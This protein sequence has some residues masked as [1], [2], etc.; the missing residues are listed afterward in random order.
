[1]A[2]TIAPPIDRPLNKTYLQGFTGWSTAFGPALAE[3]SS[4]RQMENVLIGRD[5]SACVRPAMRLMFDEHADPSVQLIGSFEQFY[6]VAG[7]QILYALR[8]LDDGLIY[9]E[10]R[11]YVNGKYMDPELPGNA[12]T[13]HKDTTYVRYLQIDNRIY[14]LSN[15]GEDEVAVFDTNTSDFITITAYG[16]SRPPTAGVA[17]GGNLNAGDYNYGFFYTVTNE[18]G[19]SKPSEIAHITA[20]K[21]WTGWAAG[22]E[23]ELTGIDG[24]QWNLY[25]LFWSDDAPV[26]VEGV[27]VQEGGTGTSWTAATSSLLSS[28]QGAGHMLPSPADEDFTQPPR[29][30]QGLVA[31]DRLILVSDHDNYARIRWSSNEPG[32]YG[33]FSPGK[34][35]G[36]KTL[37]SGN[38][39]IPLTVRLW[40]NPQSVDTLTVLCSGLDG[41]HAAY[42]MSPASVTSLNEEIIVMAFEETTATPGTVSPYGCEVFNNSLYHPLD[43]QLMKSSTNNYNIHHK[44]MTEAI[45]PNWLNLKNKHNIV[46]SE[47]DGRLYYIVHNPDGEE[48]E[49]G[50]MGNEIW[51]CDVGGQDTAIWSR[52]LI[53]ATSL[54]K[55]ES[56]GRLYMGVVRPEGIYRLD[57]LQWMDEWAG[58][59]KA[60]P[61]FFQ[62]NTN[63]AN[64]ALDGVVSLHQVNPT[65]GDAY[66]VIRY[67]IQSWTVDGKALSISKVYRQHI[68]IEPGRELPFDHDDRLLVQR[69]AHQWFFSAG[70]ETDPETGEVLPS[71]GR[72]N[73]VQFTFTP[74]TVNVGYYTGSV[75]TYEYAHAGD[76]WTERTS[77][78]GIPI[79][80]IDPRR[81]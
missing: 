30:A 80:M 73:R 51:V 7:K 55:L 59:D 58:G 54:R 9:F 63:G 81:P 61:W 65:F 41:Y 72:V 45:A 8:D 18:F 36:Y 22:D 29:C 70:S 38:L 10:T 56:K 13:F 17:L 64:R 68:D 12:P 40:Q 4:M 24:D 42:Y 16:N 74:E 33:S 76:F 69:K 14:C 6:G 49:P 60:I 67:G 25:F 53:Q 50:C 62:T 57:E 52:F 71:Y 77:I 5:G 15:S 27:L 47:F 78:N 48:L 39:Q 43:D 79:P 46:V 28:V 11:V 32:S 44:V 20:D 37:S 23:I 75:Q 66:G 19:E 26:P 34:G 35:G 3:D 2:D 31:A 1:M 21:K